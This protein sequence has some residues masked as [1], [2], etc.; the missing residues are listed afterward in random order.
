LY[1]EP[2]REAATK[3]RDALRACDAIIPV[4]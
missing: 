3:L 1:V 4:G 2:R